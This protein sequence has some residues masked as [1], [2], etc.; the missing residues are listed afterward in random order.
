MMNGHNQLIGPFMQKCILTQSDIY[1]SLKRIFYLK[2][3]FPPEQA[4][5]IYIF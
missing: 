5:K 3:G 1:A 2:K 4:E